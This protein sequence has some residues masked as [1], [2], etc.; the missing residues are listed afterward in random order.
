M[1]VDIS[2]TYMGLKLNSPFIAASSGFT[3]KVSNIVELEKAG[4]G[5]IVL[6]SL[7]EEQI[8]GESNFLDAINAD[9]PENSDYLQYYVREGALSNYL[10]LVKEAKAAV[11]IPIIAS[12]NCYNSGSWVSFAKDI[13]NAGADAIEINIYSLPLNLNDTSKNIEEEYFNVISKIKATVKIP[14]AVKI[15]ENF[16]S[17]PKFVDSLKGY[18]ASAVVLFNKFYHPDIDVNRLQIIGPD[19]FSKAGDCLRELRWIAIISSVVR[20][21]E[22]SASSGVLSGKDC[23]KLILSGATTLQTCSALY[24]Q[25]INAISE[26]TE[27]LKAFME[28][29]GY[30]KL[31]DF[32]GLLN[33][34]NVE[35]PQR[36]ERVQFVKTFGQK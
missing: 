6:K 27:E 29:K 17:L 16:T 25:G 30:S 4:A 3:A 20:G 14:V 35:N 10:K 1:N 34:S 22:I 18:G 24:K 32:R 11:K 36:Y 31:E 28:W 26:F 19:P 15:G 21:V 8:D 5:A 12:I 33:Y 9:H 23:I 13:E 2:T 7:F